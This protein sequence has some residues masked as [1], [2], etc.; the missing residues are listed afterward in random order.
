MLS[1][2]KLLILTVL[3]WSL[4]L[5][6]IQDGGG[7]GDHVRWR[8]RSPA[9][10]PPIK[11]TWF[12]GENQR[13]STEGKKSFRN[14]ATDQKPCGG[15]GAISLPPPPL[16]PRLGYDFACM[17]EGQVRLP[18][19]VKHDL[20]IFFEQQVFPLFFLAAVIDINST[21]TEQIGLLPHWVLH[22]W[23]WFMPSKLLFPV[24]YASVCISGSQNGD[25]F[26]VMSCVLIGP[27]D[28][29]AVSQYWCAEES[30]QWIGNSRFIFLLHSSLALR[31]KYRVRRAW[32]IKR[33]ICR[34]NLIRKLWSTT[35][36]HILW[37][38]RFWGACENSRSHFRS[39]EAS[40]LDHF[41]YRPTQ[42]IWLWFSG[43]WVARY[44][45]KWEKIGK[46][47]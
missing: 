18:K 41:W 6:K 25:N 11:Y 19:L 39:L 47:S 44:A 36:V 29:T 15:R 34:L 43:G 24:V 12:C 22:Y 40:N 3:T 31:A 33:L 2:K 7:D 10:P 13:I 30:E 28:I 9:A 27:F 4:I 14:T 45:W 46:I 42:T 20:G 37:R 17:S 8:H 32:L 1:A 5:D 16:V 21:L 35:L 23:R 26:R 38:W